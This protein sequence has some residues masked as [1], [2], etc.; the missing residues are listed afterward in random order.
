LKT[1][2]IEIKHTL[3]ENKILEVNITKHSSKDSSLKTILGLGI[4]P[5]S[6][7]VTLIKM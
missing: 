7:H 1:K 3:I 6:S 5:S 2:L 4:A